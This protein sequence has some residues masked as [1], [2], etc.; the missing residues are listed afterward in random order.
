V[1]TV[2]LPSSLDSAALARRLGELAGDE[3]NVLVE[4]LLHLDEFDRRRA[5]VDAGH[6]SLW[7]YC[8]RVLHLREGA[9]GRR[10]GAMRVLRAFPRLESALRDGRLC[11]STASLL[12]PVLTNENLEELVARAAYKTKAEVEELVVTLR[13]RPEPQEGIR[14]LPA[15]APAAAA[16]VGSGGVL[17]IGPVVSPPVDAE[18]RVAPVPTAPVAT[19]LVLSPTTPAKVEPVAE[20]RW[21]VRVTLDADGK[22]DLETL[23]ALL[24]HKIPNGELGAVLHEAIR[25]G[26][27][28]HGRRKGA[29]A[30][31]QG[32]RR[33]GGRP[34]RSEPVSTQ[35]PSHYIPAG[36][37]REVWKRDGGRCTFVGPDGG[38]CNSRWQLEFDHVTPTALG[39]C[40][41]VENVRLRCRAHNMLHA[42]HVHGREH[43]DT[44][45]RPD[46]TIA[47][48]SS[49]TGRV[50]DGGIRNDGIRGPR[51]VPC[52]R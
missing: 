35:P 36:V 29:S 42:E 7:E 8:L 31:A 10:I 41:T 3:R 33:G 13:P 48:D 1:P 14:K 45:R 34:T 30:P 21:S 24:S 49:S 50:V 15:P 6:R 2:D 20:D 37:R 47:G 28:K 25:C 5:Y 32:R 40:S 52:V 46:P 16:A 27:E 18:A 44:F 43:M 19:P 51:L 12:G 9:A 23:R 11:S 38:R 4:F 26:I 22:T 17:P 39:G